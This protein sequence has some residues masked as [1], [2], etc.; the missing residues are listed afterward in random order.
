MENKEEEMS[1]AERDEI[2]LTGGKF[3]VVRFVG[4]TETEKVLV[5]LLSSKKSVELYALELEEEQIQF[6]TGKDEAW[7][8]SLHHDSHAEL[9][10]VAHLLNFRVYRERVERGVK[11]GEANIRVITPFLAALSKHRGSSPGTPTPPSASV[12]PSTQSSNSPASSP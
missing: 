8:D 10:E 6:V 5:R 2:I 7:V 12:P 11:N 4:K 1:I 3:V 9:M